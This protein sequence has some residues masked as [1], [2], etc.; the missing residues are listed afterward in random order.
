MAYKHRDVVIAWMDGETIQFKF[1][2]DWVDEVPFS[3]AL[4]IPDI[5]HEY[6]IKPKPVMIRHALHSLAT[7][8]L[9]YVKN[10]NEKEDKVSKEAEYDPDII[11]L[12]DWHEA[13][14]SAPEN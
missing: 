8:P 1:D 2:G 6:R 11:W 10:Y 14:F 9:V 7:A 13:S 5:Y 4:H 12:D 3:Q